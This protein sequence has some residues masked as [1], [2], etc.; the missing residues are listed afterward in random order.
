MKGD[1]AEGPSARKA[2]ARASLGKTS[3][4][5]DILHNTCC[6]LERG[7][8]VEMRGVERPFAV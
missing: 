2:S 7:L 1:C 4:M 5:S 3:V 8:R 6:H